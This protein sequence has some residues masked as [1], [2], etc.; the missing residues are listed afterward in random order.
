MTARWEEE[1]E[2][3]LRAGTDLVLRPYADAAEQAVEILE[4]DD[5]DR[6]GGKTAKA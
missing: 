1:A 4:R 3:F 5:P 2:A 6:P